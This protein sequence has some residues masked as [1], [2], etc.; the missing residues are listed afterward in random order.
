MTNA[1][2]MELADMRDLGSRAF[3]RWGSSPHARTIMNESRFSNNFIEKRDLSYPESLTTRGSPLFIGEA[4]FS[5]NAQ[6]AKLIFLCE[7]EI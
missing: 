2:M 7:V 4:L 1:G 5:Q 6:N 3:R